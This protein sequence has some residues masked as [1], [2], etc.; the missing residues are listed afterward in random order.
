METEKEETETKIP[1]PAARLLF[2][3]GAPLTPGSFSL[4]PALV[5]LS[6]NKSLHFNNAH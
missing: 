5:I 3:I 1:F 4:L 6:E 2:Q